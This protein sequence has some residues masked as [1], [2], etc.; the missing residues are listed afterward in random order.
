MKRG[1]LERNPRWKIPLGGLILFCLLGGFAAITMTGVSASFHSSEVYRQ[2]V[3]RCAADPQASERLGEPIRPGWLVLGELHVNGSEGA[4]D[5]S[6]PVSG[7][8]GKGSIHTVAVKSAGVWRFTTLQVN[9]E[10][11]GAPIDLLSVEPPPERQF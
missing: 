6:I 7:S 5:F 1:W 3:A 8:R 11:A 4:A 10:G 2:A 9:V